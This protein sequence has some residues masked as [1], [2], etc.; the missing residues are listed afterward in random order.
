MRRQRS[1]QRG[2]RFLRISR[3]E[4]A[5][6]AELRVGVAGI[7]LDGLREIF[8]GQGEVVLLQRQFAAGHVGRSVGRLPLFD[9][10]IDDVQ[11]LLRVDALFQEESPQ[12]RLVGGV[13]VVPRRLLDDGAN[14]VDQL[15]SSRELIVVATRL[16]AVPAQLQAVWETEQSRIDRFQSVGITTQR[17]FGLQF[18][19]R[20]VLAALARCNRLGGQIDTLGVLA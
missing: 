15:P 17:Q 5:G 8:S 11:D 18:V 9:F 16:A 19:Q 1:R 10:I 6:Q 12:Q 4:C 13:A 20:P 2:L 3:R 7:E 14:L